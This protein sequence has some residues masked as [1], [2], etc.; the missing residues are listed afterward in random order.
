MKLRYLTPLVGFVV[1]TVTIGYGIGF[2]P[3]TSIATGTRP[4]AA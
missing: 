3:G 4:A 2:I 1:P